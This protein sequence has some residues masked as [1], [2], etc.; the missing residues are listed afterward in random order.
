MLNPIKN[1]S[2]K[3]HFKFGDTV[4]T[5]IFAPQFRNEVM[6]LRG[7]AVGSSSGS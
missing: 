6:T 4:K 5:R 1:N 3:T 7:G 2:K